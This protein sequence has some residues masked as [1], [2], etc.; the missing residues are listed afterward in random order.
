M[1]SKNESGQM[2]LETK[3]AAKSGTE[4]RQKQLPENAAKSEPTRDKGNSGASLP[5]PAPS[6]PLPPSKPPPKRSRTILLVLAAIGLFFA[7]W[8]TADQFFAYTDDAYAT[9]DVVAVAPEVTGPIVAVHVHDNQLLKAGTL[10]ISIDPTPFKIELD[11]SRAQLAQ[12]QAQLLVDKAQLAAAQASLTSAQ[13]E[14]QLAQVQLRRMQTLNRERVTDQQSLDVQTARER[15]AAARFDL[16]EADVNRAEN[17]LQLHQAAVQAAQAAVAMAEWRLEK[18]EIR[19]PADGPISNLT[20]RPGDMAVV[21]QPLL[22]IVD[23]NA[24]RIEANYKERFLHHFKPGKTAWV[25]LDAFPGHWYRA[26]IQ[27]MS[28]AIGRGETAPGLVPYV[29]PTVDWIRLTRRIPV[30][31]QIEDPPAKMN[32]FM[33]SDARVFVFY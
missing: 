26:K 21:H 28:H 31:I 33:G 1:P 9:S 11:Q 6:K 15:E 24:W 29:A 20:V 10:L 14:L 17:T 19:A 22:T 3:G 32:L 18:T 27:G 7:V 16:T 12:A 25:W 30:R 8:W 13:A 23:A 4:I 5:G 2:P